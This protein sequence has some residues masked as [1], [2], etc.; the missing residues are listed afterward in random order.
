MGRI[1]EEREVNCNEKM[2]QYFHNLCRAFM[3]AD[4]LGKI[5]L[6]AEICRVKE[7]ILFY[8]SMEGE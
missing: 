2:L 5:T 4:V 7:K 3:Y 8:E 1:L 6:K